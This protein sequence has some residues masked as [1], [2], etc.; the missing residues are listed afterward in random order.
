MN[1]LFRILLMVICLGAT[2]FAQADTHPSESEI[3]QYQ[4]HLSI[5]VSVQSDTNSHAYS[6]DRQTPIKQHH[7]NLGGDVAIRYGS[8]ARHN[9]Q[10]S[11]PNYQVV[12]EIPAPLEPRLVKGYVERFTANLNWMLHTHPSSSLVSGWKQSNL[13]YTQHTH[14]NSHA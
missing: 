7:V 13:L 4:T 6:H 3:V 5:S 11:K 8:F 9:E 14:F 1:T 10:Q 2:S 12:I